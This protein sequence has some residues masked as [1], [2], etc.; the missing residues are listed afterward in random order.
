MEGFANRTELIVRTALAL[1]Q[2]RVGDERPWREV[3][4]SLGLAAGGHFVPGVK[5]ANGGPDLIAAVG[6][7]E[8][9]LAEVNPAA[10]VGLAVRGTGPFAAPLPLRVIGVL[11]AWD[12]MGFAVAERTGITSL[13]ELA[14]HRQPLRLSVR[15][16]ASH[17]SRLLINEVFAAL[18]TRLEDIVGR[19]GSLQMAEMPVDPIRLAAIRDE[20]IDGVMDEGATRWG[21]LA[22]EHGMRLLSVD[23]EARKRLDSIGWPVLT[24]PQSR[25][26]RLPEPITVASL[27]GYPLVTHDSLSEDTA[28]R[29][30]LALERTLEEL[31][32]QGARIDMRRL[33]SNTDEAPLTAP[34][35]PGAERFYSERGL[36]GF[37]T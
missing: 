32:W 26:P 8:L 11:P 17:S 1:S 3:H 7:G 33:C 9:D 28:Y 37:R 14:A 29:M 30:C 16:T 21:A 4:L 15:E 22:L 25:L 36:L 18:G 6:A 2:Q 27:S 34:L 35:H 12:G 13:D 24:L 19:G 31:P 5:L 23:G 10:L 20:S